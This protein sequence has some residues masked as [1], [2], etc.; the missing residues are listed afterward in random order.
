MPPEFSRDSGCNSLPMTSVVDRHPS[1]NVE[2]SDDRHQGRLGICLRQ[3]GAETTVWRMLLN[4][5][6]KLSPY[7]P[8]KHGHLSPFP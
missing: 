5:L 2:C 3:G 6:L 1:S 7:V 4:I 8:S